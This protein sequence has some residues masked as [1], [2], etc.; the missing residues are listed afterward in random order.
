MISNRIK[1][2]QE[3]FLSEVDRIRPMSRNDQGEFIFC[4]EGMETDK[5]FVSALNRI[6][7]LR[8]FGKLSLRFEDSYMFVTV[9]DEAP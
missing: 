7:G 6:L 5:D 4:L 2:I 8:S 9:S 1:S 3:A